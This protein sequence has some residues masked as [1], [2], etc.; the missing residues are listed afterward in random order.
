MT[1]QHDLAFQDCA[2]AAITTAFYSVFCVDGLEHIM[3]QI[4][5]M[6]IILWLQGR[7]AEAVCKM[8]LTRMPFQGRYVFSEACDQFIKQVT[9]RNGGTSVSL[10]LSGSQMSHTCRW[11]KKSTS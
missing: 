7:T 10:H 2:V 8:G 5:I 3:R 11:F 4:S 9:S 6:H 1:N